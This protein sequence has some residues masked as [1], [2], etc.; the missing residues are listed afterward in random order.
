MLNFCFK[1]FSEVRSLFNPINW[2]HGLQK[3]AIWQRRLLHTQSYT[4]S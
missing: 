3:I 4:T 2:P 1:E